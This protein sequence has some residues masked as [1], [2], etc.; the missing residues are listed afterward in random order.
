MATCIQIK[1]SLKGKH[2]TAY[3]STLKAFTCKCKHP[4]AH[5][6]SIMNNTIV[7]IRALFYQ[8]DGNLTPITHWILYVTILV[9]LLSSVNRHGRK[10]SISPSNVNY[11]ANIYALKQEGCSHILVTTACGSLQ[12]N[13]HPG[14]IVVIDQ[15]IDR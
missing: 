1:I 3:Q 15:F 14:E 9:S 6:I 11:R 12:E 13:I 10:H 5:S 2:F 7:Q 8:C 4:L